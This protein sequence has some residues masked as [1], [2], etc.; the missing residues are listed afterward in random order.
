MAGYHGGTA[1]VHGNLYLIEAGTGRSMEINLSVFGGS[2]W[3]NS[4]EQKCALSG[5]ERPGRVHVI[6]Y[7]TDARAVEVKIVGTLF[8]SCR[9]T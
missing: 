9:E 1:H 6:P 5:N 4:S 7:E 8:D 3:D 2:C